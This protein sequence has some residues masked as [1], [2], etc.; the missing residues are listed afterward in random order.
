MLLLAL[1][2]FTSSTFAQRVESPQGRR[3]LNPLFDEVKMT[4]NI[5][6]AEKKNELTGKSEPLRLRVFEPVGDS[7]RGRALFLLTPG[8][9]FVVNGDDW[10]NDVATEIAK[11]GYVVAIN[12]Y[13]LN[14][15]IDTPDKF[16]RALAMAVADQRDALQYLIKDAA[17]ANT[18]GIDPE[19]IFVG[20]HSA[21]AITSMHTAYLDGD[22]AIIDVMANAFEREFTLP[23]PAQMLP[24]KGVINLAGA[25]PQLQIINRK[26]VALLS[27][28]GD[29]DSVVT[30]DKDDV[31]FGSVAIHEYLDTVGTSGRL[32]IIEGAKHNDTALPYLCEEC[33]P[34]MKR[35]MFNELAK[36]PKE[37][38]IKSE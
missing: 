20:G 14:D 16:S 35:F 33:I 18:F 31:L 4:E 32:H 11:A 15:A 5:V 19:K 25:L 10:M 21:G 38:L 30:H 37:A 3:Y 23:A 8:G 34:L 1:S 12:K 7:D 24:I 2:M 27:I 22:D 6:F 36:L 13:R 26:D 9:G 17:K 29:R 28:H